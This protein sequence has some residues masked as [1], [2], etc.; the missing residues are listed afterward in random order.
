MRLKGWVLLEVF[1][2]A[3]GMDAIGGFREAQ[4]MGATGGF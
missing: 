1:S 4:G 3:Q 2:E